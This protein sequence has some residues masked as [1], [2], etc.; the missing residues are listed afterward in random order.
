MLSKI[1]NI[2]IWEITIDHFYST[3]ILL[4]SHRLIQVRNVGSTLLIKHICIVYWK[5]LSFCDL[6]VYWT[7]G[8]V[9]CDAQLAASCCKP[10]TYLFTP[11]FWRVILTLK[12]GHTDLVVGVRSGFISRVYQSCKITSLCV[13]RLRFVPPWLTSKQT[14]IHNHTQAAFDQ[15]TWKPQPAKLKADFN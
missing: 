1:H 15:L 10:A 11:T 7:L 6:F 9:G 2:S 12:V 14:H 5:T 4:S 8:S 13:Q 3:F